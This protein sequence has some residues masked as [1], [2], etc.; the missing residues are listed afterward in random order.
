VLWRLA[1]CAA[2]A[3]CGFRSSAVPGDAQ[4]GSDARDAMLV[5]DAPG[6]AIDAPPGAADCLR[7]WED[8]TL[9]ISSVEKLDR[10]LTSSE[11]R[12][13]WVSP[14]G[15][16]LYFASDRLGTNDI[17]RSTRDDVS[18]P[19]D[20]AIRLDNLSTTTNNE[21]G[22]SITADQTLLVLSRDSGPSGKAQILLTVPAVAPNDFP[23]P[24]TRLIGN[25]NENSADQRD[26]FLTADGLR[27]YL[28]VD[29][30][31]AALPR[32]EVAARTDRN[33]EFSSPQPVPGINDLS[34]N[35]DPA[36]S[37]GELVLLFSSTRSGGSGLSDLWYARRQDANDPFGPPAPIPTVNSLAFENDPMLSADG[38]ELYFSSTR[39]AGL[40][41]DLYV[42]HVVR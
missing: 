2:F 37:V 3:G 15:K 17:F 28:T 14:N 39:G 41:H 24:D 42:A 19:F 34:I 9:Q 13:P 21:D 25:V 5:V 23:S 26:P 10:V 11:D 12:D 40:D 7:H 31:G 30:Q 18:Q 22:A 35:A 8:G 1:L 29:P 33:A 27:L 20:N 16:I 6:A 38:C 32:I 36:V 4:P